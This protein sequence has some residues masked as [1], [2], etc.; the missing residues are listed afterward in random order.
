MVRGRVNKVILDSYGYYL[1]MEKGCY[2]IKDRNGKTQK[3]PQFETEI[4]EVILTSGNMVS[5]GALASFGF[6]NIDVLIMTKRGEPVATLKPFDDDSHVQTRISQYEAYKNTKALEIARTFVSSKLEGQN[7]ILNK[8]GFKIHK[9]IEQQIKSIKA[10]NLVSL[11]KRIMHIEAMASKDYFNQIFQ[12]IPERIRPSNRTTLNAYDGINNIFNL[13]YKLLFW[14][15]YRAIAKAHLEP[16]LGFLHSLEAGKP[17]LVCDFQEL[18][19][20]LIDDFVIRFCQKLNRKDFVMKPCVLSKKRIGKREFLND[21][22]TRKLNREL[23]EYFRF[24]V[25]VERIRHG[26]KQEIETL[27][28]EEALLFAQYLRNEKQN[29]I[30]RIPNPPKISFK[31]EK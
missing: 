7:I 11:R 10:E 9:N 20:Y 1:G 3:Y 29:W 8:Y 15:C 21:S 4:G 22:M 14:K 27:I 12:L 2:I 5:I 18:Y 6:W 26:K 24:N 25:E 16:Y 30:P 23:Q 17:S 13:A 28:S 31:L 19:R